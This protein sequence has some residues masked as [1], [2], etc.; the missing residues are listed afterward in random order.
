MPK[1]IGSEMRLVM[2]S[3]THGLHHKLNN[4]PEGDCLIHAGDFCNRGALEEAEDFL[5]WFSNAPHPYKIFCAGNHD[6]CFEIAPTAAKALIPPNVVYLE[7]SS[8]NIS[9]YNFY[10]SPV[11]P[12]FLDWA[13]NVPRGADIK[14]Y[15]DRIPEAGC[16]DVLIT[17][18]PPFGILDQAVPMFGS[19]HLGCE[20]LAERVKDSVPLVHC[21]GHIHGGYGKS[22]IGQTQ[23]F[24][25]SQVNESYRVVNK[26]WVIEI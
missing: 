12:W 25:C 26:P 7:N 23:H 10:G 1:R 24:N 22:S 11:T 20:E 13:F 18:G 15:W 17:H 8:I 21:F 2:I 16:V 19:E 3:D 14:K 4:I 9:G 5:K 6:W